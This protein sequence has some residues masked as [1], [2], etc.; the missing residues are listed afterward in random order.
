MCE[1]VSIHLHLKYLFS[2]SLYFWLF[3]KL[4]QAAQTI[5][6]LLI[7]GLKRGTNLVLS[8]PLFLLLCITL[9]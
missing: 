8:L 9:K 1:K 3:P 6:T 7:W 5:V 4:S 2:L